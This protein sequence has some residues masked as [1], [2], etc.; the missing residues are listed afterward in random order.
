M[1]TALIILDIQ[2]D[3]LTGG[4]LPVPEGDKISRS[5]TACLPLPSICSL[6]QKTGTRKS[7][8][9]LLPIIQ[10]KLWETEYRSDPLR[11]FYGRS[12]VFKKLSEQSSPK[13]F[14]WKRFRLFFIKG[15]ILR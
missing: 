5:S 14:K 8:A 6:L 1:K 9:A 2:N 15:Q 12:T 4:A 3:F 11:K 10:A 13:I 7:I